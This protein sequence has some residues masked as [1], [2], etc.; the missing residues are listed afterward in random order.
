MV[1]TSKPE[2]ANTFIIEYSLPATLRSKLDSAESEEPCTKKRPEGT[3]RRPAWRTACGRVQVLHCLYWPK[4]HPFEFRAPSGTEKPPFG[5]Q[6]ARAQNR[7]RRQ[8]R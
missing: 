1:Q 4:I 7:S 6:P 2:R 5:R 3:L 8:I